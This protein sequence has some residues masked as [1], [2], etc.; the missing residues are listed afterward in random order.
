MGNGAKST[1]D[2]STY[3]G[4][5]FIHITGKNGYKEISTEWNK[6]YPDDPKEFHGK[7]IN[8]LEKDVEV[9]MKASMVY[10]KIKGLNKEVGKDSSFEKDINNIGR[11]INGNDPPNGAKLRLKYAT[12]IYQQFNK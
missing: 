2:G 7:D 9:A 3:L 1:K 12:D 11:S 8:L 4:K 10:W 6:L 5:G